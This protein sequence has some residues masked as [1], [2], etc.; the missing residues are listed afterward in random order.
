MTSFLHD[1]ARHGPYFG[2]AEAP[3]CVTAPI[4]KARFSVSRLHCEV[5]PGE[6]R[7]LTIPPQDAYFVMLYLEDVA[8]CDVLHDGSSTGT[9]RYPQGSICLVHLADGA[10]IRLS[11][12]LDSL[13]FIVPK[14][15][16]EELDQIAPGTSDGRLECRRGESDAVIANLGTAFL[17]MFDRGQ[18]PL[19][20]TFKHMAIALCGH[21]LHRYGAG[22][23]SRDGTFAASLSAGQE[24]A[25]K[26][27]IARNLSRSA[28]PVSAIAAAAGLPASCFAQS[29]QK[30]VG[31]TL[32]QWVNGSRVARAKELLAQRTLSLKTIAGECG[33]SDQAQFNRVFAKAT[34]MP[35]AVWR[36]TRLQ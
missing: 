5:A 24:V 34:G 36:M 28:I 27:Y 23:T 33:F 26:T 17:A 7:V 22:R 32:A 20:V 9:R 21:L 4:G 35:P 31:C 3:R 25:A 19:P 15:L 13:G 16:F 18:A 2:F 6:A 30:A 8:H 14:A 11:S 12:T 1:T 10:V 29:F